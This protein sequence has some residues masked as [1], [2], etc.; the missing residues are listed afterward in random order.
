M[1][2]IHDHGCISRKKPYSQLP[3]DRQAQVLEEICAFSL[4]GMEKDVEKGKLW[5]MFY[6]AAGV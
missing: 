5:W 3:K 6:T 1:S 4:K 2:P